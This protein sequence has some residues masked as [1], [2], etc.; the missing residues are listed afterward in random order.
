MKTKTL[1]LATTFLFSTSTIAE[2]WYF[3]GGLGSMKLDDGVDTLSPKNLYLR[4]GYAFN[5]NFEI[6]LESSSTISSDQ[7]SEAPDVDF[8]VDAVTFYLRL[9]MPVSEGIK[10]YGQVGRSNT[11]ITAEFNGFEVSDDDNDMMYGL[12]AEIDLG[13]N[14]TYIALNYSNYYDDDNFDISAFNIGIGFRFY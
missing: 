8:D 5:E 6:G 10:V 2:N 12:G 3:G 7:L 13:D 9:G 14:S 1:L 11:E 4:G